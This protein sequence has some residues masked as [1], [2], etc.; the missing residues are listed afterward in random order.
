MTGPSLTALLQERASRQPDAAAYTFIEYDVDPRG[1]AETLSWRQVQQ[2]AQVVA[3]ELSMC[4][5]NGSRVAILAPQ[6]LEYIVAFL[7]AVQAGAIA[8]PLPIPQVGLHDERVSAVLRD[9]APSAILTT[10]CAVSEVTKYAESFNGGTAP[11]LIEVDSLDLDVP[12]RPQPVHC[13][14]S[15]PAYL[16]Y[17]SGSTRAP[18]GVVVTHKNVVTNVQQAFADLIGETGAAGMRLV[19]WLPFYHDMGLLLGVCGSLVTGHSAVL[20]S[21]F[22]FLRRPVRWMQMLAADHPTLSAAPNFAFDLAVWRISD[23]EMAGHDLGNVLGIASGAERVHVATVERFMHRFA[24]FGLKDTAI[25]PSYGLAEATVYVAS[26][27]AGRPVKTVRFDNEKLSRG[28]A[29]ACDTAGRGVH[30]IGHGTCRSTVLRIVDPEGG[31]EN[32]AGKVGEIWVHGDNVANGYWQKPDETLGT[33]SASLVSPGPD[34]PK[35]PWLRTGDLGVISDGEL[36]IIGRIKDLLIIHGTNHYPDDIEATIQQVTKGRVAAIAVPADGTE[37]LVAVA[38]VRMRDTL[39]DQMQELSS[40]KC[41]VISA[42]SN[43]HR[44]RAADIVFV[45]PGSIPTTTSGKVRRTA[46]AKLYQRAEFDRLDAMP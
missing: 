30:L 18:A 3:D 24:R 25:R 28:Y 11:L 46:C 19:S 2:R 45:T 26:A 43:A 22:S 9:C 16:Q 6:G 32:P 10:S 38:E 36:F 39:D 44:L 15:R 41:Q 12:R 37:R 4:G 1:I 27:D 23:E 21:P 34:T 33:F 8:V 42:I 20:M 17:T 35:A 14:P 5:S 29:K 40:L 7:G 13:P 31:T